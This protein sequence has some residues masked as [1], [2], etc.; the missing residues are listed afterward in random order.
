MFFYILLVLLSHALMKALAIEGR[1]I[2]FLVLTLILLLLGITRQT[3]RER[4]S[5]FIRSFTNPMLADQLVRQERSFTRFALL[6]FII[7]LASVSVF[8]ALALQYL[9]F[10]EDFS[11]I[12][13]F[14][15]LL[16]GFVLLTMVR[17]AVYSA[18]SWLFALSYLQQIHTFHWLLTNFIL[19]LM[20]LPFSALYFFGPANLRGLWVYGGLASLAI[21]FLIRVLRLFYISSNS[22]RVPLMYNFLYLCAL[23]ILPLLLSIAVILRQ[24]GG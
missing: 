21:F 22:F 14:A 12:G 11:F 8:G 13:L 3:E 9:S 23:E 7:T 24:L 19:S 6:V 4:F 5:L 20:L 1:E 15:A 16:I 18:A 10:F 17:T 2:E